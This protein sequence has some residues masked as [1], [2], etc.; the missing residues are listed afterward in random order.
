[1]NFRANYPPGGTAGGRHTSAPGSHHQPLSHASGC[2]P[3]PSGRQTLPVGSHHS[4]FAQ[5]AELTAGVAIVTA[6]IQANAII[7]TAI[8]TANGH[9]H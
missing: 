6:A 5:S 9:P 4:P 3:T 7:K 1:V 8:K 2:G